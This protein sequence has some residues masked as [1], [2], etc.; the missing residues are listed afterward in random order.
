MATR[1]IVTTDEESKKSSS[2]GWV[3]CLLFLLL[4]GA[5]QRK[6]PLRE[7][8]RPILVKLLEFLLLLFQALYQSLPD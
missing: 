3:Y 4:L 7:L 5:L 2:W 6:F 8:A 1:V